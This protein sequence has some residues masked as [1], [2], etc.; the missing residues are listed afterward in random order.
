M[1]SAA[2]MTKSGAQLA[3]ASWPLCN[4]GLIPDLADPWI[5]LNVIHRLL[6][7]AFL[8]GAIM[9]WQ[10]LRHDALANMGTLVLVLSVLEILLGGLLVALDIPVWSG[11]LHQALAVLVFAAVAF[12]LWHVNPPAPVPGKDAH[13]RLSEARG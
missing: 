10:R 5:R 11:V 3:C 1:V 2:V 13:V 12:V 8:I 6:A 9:L 4:Q 7:L